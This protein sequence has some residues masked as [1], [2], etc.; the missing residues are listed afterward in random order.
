LC[1][2]GKFQQQCEDRTLEGAFQ[3]YAVTETTHCVELWREKG[4]A[5]DFESFA[6]QFQSLFVAERP[7]FSRGVHKRLATQ[8]RMKGQSLSVDWSVASGADFK[9]DTDA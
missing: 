6:S 8:R 7:S 3:I 1:S 4:D 9:L 5:A 2:Q